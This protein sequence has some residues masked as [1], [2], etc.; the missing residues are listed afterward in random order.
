MEDPRVF[1]LFP[2]LLLLLDD[3]PLNNLFQTCC[4]TSSWG[5]RE[6]VR[7]S[8]LDSQWRPLFAPLLYLPLPLHQLPF[9]P[10]SLPTHE[11]WLPPASATPAPSLGS[12]ANSMRDVFKSSERICFAH[13]NLARS[14]RVLRVL[15][16]LHFPSEFKITFIPIRYMLRSSPTL[17]HPF[18]AK[19]ATASK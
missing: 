12:H 3:W 7:F 9:S 6:A 19:Y 18:T 8:R 15:D 17:I 14:T 4:Q 10:P 13:P 11:Q 2:P 5:K 16:Q 1:S